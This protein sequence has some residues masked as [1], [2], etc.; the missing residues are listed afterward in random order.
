L[1]T[2]ELWLPDQK[3]AHE[4]RVHQPNAAQSQRRTADFSPGDERQQG[5]DERIQECTIRASGLSLSQDHRRGWPGASSTD[6]TARKVKPNSVAP[7]PAIAAKNGMNSA[8]TIS[9]RLVVCGCRRCEHVQQLLQGGGARSTSQ[10]GRC[11]AD[12]FR[13]Q[14]GSIRDKSGGQRADAVRE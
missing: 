8:G 11:P 1:I 12:C 10:R 3:Y 7:T 2:A 6:E 5:N 13:W 14:S 9:Q 4:E